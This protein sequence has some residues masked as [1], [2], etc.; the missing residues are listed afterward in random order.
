[1]TRLILAAGAV[2]VRD[3]C[4]L[5]VQRSHPPQPGRW[6]LPGG[7]C[8][9]GETPADA[10]ARETLE[11][12]GVR[13]A[14]GAELGRVRI[15]HGDNPNAP[16]FDPARAGIVYDIVDFAATFVSGEPAAGDDAADA[17]WVPL[18]EL[19]TWPVTFGLLDHLRAFGVPVP[20]PDPS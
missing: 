9:A 11:E 15:P 10:A 3:G 5:L 8:E 13:I 6:T 2:V 7:R 4:L 19:P 1:M 18:A 14:V 17:A 12:T 20:D 16:H